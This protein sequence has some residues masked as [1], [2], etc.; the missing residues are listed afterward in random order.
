MSIEKDIKVVGERNTVKL[1][2]GVLRRAGLRTGDTVQIIAETG[3][4]T[5]VPTVM[6]IARS[7]E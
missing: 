7:D 4:I 3:K 1:S 5:I 2:T 6:P